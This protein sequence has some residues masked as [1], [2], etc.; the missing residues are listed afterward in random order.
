MME[1]GEEATANVAIR[2]RETNAIADEEEGVIDAG[3]T[4]MADGTEQGIVTSRILDT[5]ARGVMRCE[6]KRIDAATEKGGN[7]GRS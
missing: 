5:R 6:R 3:K 2:E 1:G 4:E 7:R